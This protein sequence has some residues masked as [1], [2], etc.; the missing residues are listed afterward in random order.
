MEGAKVKQ[1][2]LFEEDLKR[3]FKSECSRQGRDMTEVLHE[4]VRRWL[5]E[6]KQRVN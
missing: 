2:F 3:K 4:L 5:A 1:T 6:Q